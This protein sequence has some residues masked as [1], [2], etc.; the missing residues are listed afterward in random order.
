MEI[1]RVLKNNGLLLVS[2]S[3]AWDE[4]SAP[5]D[6]ARYTSYGLKHIFE[7]HGFEVIELIKTTTYFLAVSQIFL[8]YLYQHVFPTNKFLRPLFQLFFIFPLNILF[9]AS[10]LIMPRRYEY[11]CSSVLFAKKLPL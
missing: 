4:H 9:L 10:N 3:F 7:K 6:Y 2:S 11:F 1:N 8:A 5:N